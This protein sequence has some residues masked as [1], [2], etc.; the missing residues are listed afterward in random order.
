MLHVSVHKGPSSGIKT[1]EVQHKTFRTETCSGIQC[2]ISN[3]LGKV[4]AKFTLEQATK[5]E[6]GSRVVALL[7]L[8]SELDR[9]GWSTPRPG[10][11]TPGKDQV[12][13]V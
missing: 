10:R 3:I 4:K 5:V 12:P 11:F 6:R 9:G 13:I 2:D 1:K 7:Y 8:T